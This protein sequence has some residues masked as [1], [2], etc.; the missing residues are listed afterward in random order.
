M[1]EKVY[2]IK[3]AFLPEDLTAKAVR[4]GPAGTDEYTLSNVGFPGRIDK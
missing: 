4:V 1:G 3:R 2:G